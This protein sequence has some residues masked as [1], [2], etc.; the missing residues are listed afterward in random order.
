MKPSVVEPLAASLTRL[1][2]SPLM[3]MLLFG[4]GVLV[5]GA[6]LFAIGSI[7]EPAGVEPLAKPEWQLP[8]LAASA[9]SPVPPV[10][11][12][13]QTLT[14]PIFAKSR[15]PSPKANASARPELSDVPTPPPPGL[16][17]SAIAKFRDVKRAFIVT[18]S[19]PDGQWVAIGEPIDGWTV[20]D[21]HSL[22]VTLSSG[23]NNVQLKLYS[24]EPPPEDSSPPEDFSPP[25]HSPPK[26]SPSAHSPP[27]HSS[28]IRRRPGA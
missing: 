2:L 19:A 15:R 20:V 27:E 9:P 11:A 22:E 7:V 18:S 17:L 1:R 12:D 16:A 8:K 28:I 4:L 21:V 13:Q 24:D 14:R 26:H 6:A 3:A 25:E 10:D 23:G 5:A